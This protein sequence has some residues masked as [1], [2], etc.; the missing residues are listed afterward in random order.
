MPSK[1]LALLCVVLLAH[2][3]AAM[4]SAVGRGY[5]LEPIPAEQ[6]ELSGGFWADKLAVNCEVTVPHCLTK[7]EQ[8]GRVGN[9]ETAAG[10][11]EG[12]KSRHGFDDTDLYKTIEAAALCLA[13][14]SDPKLEQQADELIKLIAAAQ[15]D[16]GYLYTHWTISRKSGE[17][18][19]KRFSRLGSSHELYNAGHLY[20]AAVAYYRATGKRQL[21]DVAVKNADYLLGQFGSGRRQD[22]PGHQEIEIGLVK[23][24]H[25]TGK[26]DYLDLADFF[27]DARGRAKGHK[28]YGAYSQ[29]HVPVL[30]QDQAVGHAV[31]ATYMYTGMVDV[32]MYGGLAGY[33]RA[34]QRIWEDVVSKKL[35][36]TGAVGASRKGEA[37]GGPYELPNAE[38]YCE[39]CASIGN[40]LWNHRLFLATGEGKYVDVLERVLYNGFL[41][42]V[43]LSGDRFFYPNPL[44]SEGASR[45]DWYKCACCPPN[46]AR[47][48]PQVPSFMYAVRGGDVYVNLYAASRAVLKSGSNT[49]RVTQDTTYPWDG[50]VRISVEPDKSRRFSIFIRV[51][52]WA[53]DKP[54]PS[55][56]YR[57]LEETAGAAVVSVNGGIVASKARSG[58]VRIHR[59]WRK[60]DKIEVSLPMAPRR[61]IAHEKV[62]EGRGLVAVERGPVVYCAEWADNDHGVDEI[63]LP[64]YTALEARYRPDLLGGVVVVTGTAESCRD[65]GG[66]VM[67]IPYYAWANRGEGKMAVWLPNKDPE[68]Q[69]K[70]TSPG[71]EVRETSTAG[72][73]FCGRFR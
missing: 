36:V 45:P 40:I 12:R 48:M 55:G 69:T 18:P 64:D 56:L 16:D 49:A 52:G 20:E 67:L 10:L 25:A 61:V 35:Y 33:L 66:G 19:F 63:R 14:D 50:Q 2:S 60:G 53:V 62:A 47:L 54:V 44:K 5:P 9:F 30:E 26:R 11:K 31:R 65:S 57:Y 39:T 51:P 42:G 8:T 70:S 24:Y 23:L 1:L 43:S 73:L 6:V 28:L 72:V 22:P 46:V 3:A 38:A 17:G 13:R 32:G 27:L 71:R 7:C 21:L 34:S 59:R 41:S 29:D 37:F 68:Q 15:E 58:F 4:S